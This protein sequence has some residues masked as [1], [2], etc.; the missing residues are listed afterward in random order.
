MK[1]PTK[2]QNFAISKSSMTR[3]QSGD[4]EDLTEVRNSE[5]YT[6][7]CSYENIPNHELA[8]LKK[9]DHEVAIVMVPFLAQC[10]L[11][12]LLQLACL[13][14]LSYD[15]PVY[16]VSSATHNRQ[17][18]VW[19]NTLNPSE[20]TKIHFHDIPTPEFSSPPPDINALS[21]FPPSWDASSRVHCFF[22]T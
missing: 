2:V 22:L 20:I 3:A 12:Q 4:S 16:Y 14:S 10:H 15:L 21:K 7:M 17:A 18:R 5:S 11:N 19:T 13:V 9:Q 8:N 6:S 1:D